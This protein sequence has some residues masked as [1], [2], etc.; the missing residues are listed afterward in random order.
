MMFS[1][2][3]KGD[4]VYVRDACIGNGVHLVKRVGRLY[5]YVARSSNE[6]KFSIETGRVYGSVEGQAYHKEIHYLMDVDRDN[7]VHRIR[8]YLSGHKRKNIDLSKVEEI[9][10]ILGIKHEERDYSTTCKKE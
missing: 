10:L 9:C 6:V 4:K 7:L 5:F 2:L 1:E 8:E 3:K